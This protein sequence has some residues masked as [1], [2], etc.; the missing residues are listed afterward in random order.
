MQGRRVIFLSF[1]ILFIFHFKSFSQ[2]AV[3]NFYSLSGKKDVSFNCIAQDANGY[4]WLGTNEG[5]VRFDGIKSEFYRKENGISDL[6][7]T[8][9]FVD[10]SQT[11]WAGTENGKVYW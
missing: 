9:I 4:L 11:V 8:S 7:I 5:D 1:C 3:K 2:Y 6:K 10:A